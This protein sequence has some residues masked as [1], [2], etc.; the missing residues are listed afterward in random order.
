VYVEP[1]IS[2]VAM[3]CAQQS[4]GNSCASLCACG[5]VVVMHGCV[6]C[7]TDKSCRGPCP[8]TQTL[9][10]FIDVHAAPPGLSSFVESSVS[11]AAADINIVFH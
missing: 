7:A 11:C 10:S 3:C 9:L 6:V 4:V 5:Y 2:C 1:E 8:Y